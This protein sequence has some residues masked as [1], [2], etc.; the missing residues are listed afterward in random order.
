MKLDNSLSNSHEKDK[1]EHN[2]YLLD[3]HVKRI[4]ER[5]EAADKWGANGQF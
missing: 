3:L 5:G 2:K 4:A 1:T